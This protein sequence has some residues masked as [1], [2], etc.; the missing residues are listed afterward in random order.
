MVSPLDLPQRT[1]LGPGPSNVHPRV[2]QALS[3][4]VVGHLDPEFFKVM[5]ANQGMLRRLFQTENKLTFP[6]SGTGSAGMEA[7]LVNLIEERD[8]VLVGINGVFGTRMADIVERC[9]GTAIRVEAPWGEIIR[10]GQPCA[11][12]DLYRCMATD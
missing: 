5:E 4:P 1:L 2:L 7:C 10:P 8:A 6:V 3:I 12:R 9:G 11:C